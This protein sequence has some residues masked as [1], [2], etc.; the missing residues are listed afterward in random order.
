MENEKNN[1]HS[2]KYPQQKSRCTHT[3]TKKWIEILFIYFFFFYECFAVDLVCVFCA[4]VTV[5]MKFVNEKKK[6]KKKLPTVIYFW[7]TFK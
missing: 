7:R 2:K 3:Y 4:N 5:E 1:P 6:Q